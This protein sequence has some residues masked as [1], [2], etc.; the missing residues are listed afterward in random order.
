MGMNWCKP[1]NRTR[2]RFLRLLALVVAFSSIAMPM[3]L[4]QEGTGADG[5]MGGYLLDARPE[6]LLY[7]SLTQTAQTISG[8]MISVEPDTDGTLTSEQFRVEGVTDGTALT[9]VVGDWLSGQL[10]M[11][12]SKDGDDLVLSY[13]TSSGAIETA[14]FVSATPDTFNQALADWEVMRAAAADLWQWLP[15]A[16]DVPGELVLF[17]EL[18]LSQDEVAMGYPGLEVVRLTE[19]AW[20]GSVMRSFGTDGPAVTGHLASAT[21]YLHRFGDPDTAGEALGAFV[22]HYMAGGWEAIEATSDASLVHVLATPGLPDAQSEEGSSVAVFARTGATVML[23]VGVASHGDPSTDALELAR[24]VLDPTYLA[25]TR[26]LSAHITTIEQATGQIDVLVEDAWEDLDDV[27]VAVGA[28]QEALD[29]LRV[30]AE[31]RPMDCLQIVNVQVAYTDV[32]VTYTDVEVARFGYDATVGDLYA[33]VTG[34]EQTIAAAQET[35]QTIDTTL[36]TMPSPLSSDAASVFADEQA[37]IDAYAVD[38]DDA[39]PELDALNTAYTDSVVS[40]DGIMA[41]GQTILE[42]AEAA[43]SC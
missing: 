39:H 43:T 15:N 33:E 42:E 26:E 30:Q 32:E 18:S 40:A 13:P 25:A 28:M 27:E 17:D 3:A 38:A 20:Q 31:V 19:W 21:V 4:A 37:V 12:G 16:T 5:L 22:E 6:A 36:A 29:E 14:V 35:F 8:Y 23:V 9:L 1:M 41:D 24:R 10:T 7:L 11:S 2:I 34:A